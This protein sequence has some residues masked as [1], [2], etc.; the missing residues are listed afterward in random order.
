[1][2]QES[3]EY[4]S[5]FTH[6]FVC[7]NQDSYRFGTPAIRLHQTLLKKDVA[8]GFLIENGG[9]DSAFYLPLFQ[10]A[11]RYVRSRMYHSDEE[12]EKL[13][14]GSLMLEGTKLR[15]EVEAEEGISR[16]LLQIPESAYTR[17]A[18]PALSVPVRVEVMREGEIV[19]EFTDRE[20]RMDASDRSTSLETDLTELMKTGEKLTIR[21]SAS[22]FDRCV[23]LD[24]MEMNVE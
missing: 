20:V 16:Y 8:H 10:D 12:T 18:A 24:T 3:P 23:L 4:L 19:A 9:H 11:F 17:E 2:E 6:Y 7:G 15:A 14:H 5:Y 22:V 13:L 1:L 21:L